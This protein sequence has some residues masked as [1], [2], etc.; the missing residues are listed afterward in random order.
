MVRTFKT[1]GPS[2]IVRILIVY[3]GLAAFAA[4]TLGGCAP[5]AGGPVEVARSELAAMTVTRG[6]ERMAERDY[7]GA[8]DAYARAIR[9]QPTSA[10][11]H[12]GLGRATEALGDMTEAIAQFRCAVKDAPEQSAYA[13]ALGDLLRRQSVTSMNRD[14]MMDGAIRAYRHALSVDD[15]CA[16]AAMGIGMCHRVMGRIDLAIEAYKHA[17]RI[18]DSLAEPHALLAGL[19]ESRSQFSDAMREYR[20]ALKLAPEDARLH[21]A[22]AAMNARLAQDRGPAQR[23]AQQRALAHY[24]RSLELDPDQPKVREAL[25]R[26]EP[27]TRTWMAGDIQNGE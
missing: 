4:M 6:H 18:D 8:A 7:A 10:E 3:A 24:R 19:Y 17:Q 26:L 11:A 15:R 13:V 27:G 25:T 12:A 2:G 23:I 20:L 1:L 21:N 14:E 22:C 5:G 9:Y 16:A